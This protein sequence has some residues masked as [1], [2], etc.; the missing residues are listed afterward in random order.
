[1][2]PSSSSLIGKVWSYL[3]D[4]GLSKGDYTEQLTFLL[5]L[6]TAPERTQLPYNQ[7]DIIPADCE[8]PSL[9]ELRE[10]CRTFE[11]G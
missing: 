7:P 2:T 3:R 4:D 5:F 11:S 1:M 9:L 6:K 10:R 8:W